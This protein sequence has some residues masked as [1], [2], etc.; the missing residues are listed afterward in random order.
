MIPN[1]DAADMN[2]KQVCCKLATARAW[3]M[4]MVD[5]HFPVP[6]RE[7][8]LAGN[9]SWRTKML[10]MPRQQQTLLNAERSPEQTALLAAGW[11]SAKPPP[12]TDDIKGIGRFTAR[13]LQMDCGGG[14][15]RSTAPAASGLLDD[16]LKWCKPPAI[17]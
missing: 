4:R 15:E 16:R 1:I 2:R 7:A 12:T 9:R 6:A 3:S 11:S 10:W 5:K 8:K 14:I 13:P 17:S